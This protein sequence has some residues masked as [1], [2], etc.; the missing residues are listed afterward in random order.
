MCVRH[1]DTKEMDC[2]L[3]YANVILIKS[4][5]SLYINKIHSI[6]YPPPLKKVWKELAYKFNVLFPLLCFKINQI[7]NFKMEFNNNA[8]IIAPLLESVWRKWAAIK[9]LKDLEVYPGSAATT[10]ATPTHRALTE[11]RN[12]LWPVGFLN[13]LYIVIQ[14]YKSE[15]TLRTCVHKSQGWWKV[16]LRWEAVIHPLCIFLLSGQERELTLLT[17]AAG[18][19]RKSKETPTLERNNPFQAGCRSWNAFWH[20]TL[21]PTYGF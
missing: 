9:N 18:V 3:T 21:L 5:F 17:K 4:I 14:T 2:Y 13:M 6:Q 11:V 16:Y 10:W 12:A 1:Q 8:G 7:N 20:L 19:S 15:D